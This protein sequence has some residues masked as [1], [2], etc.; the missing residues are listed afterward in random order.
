MHTCH[1]FRP[2]VFSLERFLP[3][4]KDELVPY[5]YMPFVLGSRNCVGKRFALM[6]AKHTTANLVVK[7]KFGQSDPVPVLDFSNGIYNLTPSDVQ[8]EVQE[9]T[10][11]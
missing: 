11:P 9:R 6:E 1:L 3:E 7:F 5:A 10:L 2:K 4:N 8:V